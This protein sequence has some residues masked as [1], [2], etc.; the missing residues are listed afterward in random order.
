MTFGAPSPW[1][2]HCICHMDLLMF[3]CLTAAESITTYPSVKAI[4]EAIHIGSSWSNR[5]DI[6]MP[7]LDSRITSLCQT[8][9]HNLCASYQYQHLHSLHRDSVHS[10]VSSCGSSEFARRMTCLLRTG[11]N[12]RIQC[13]LRCCLGLQAGRRDL[14]KPASRHRYSYQCLQSVSSAHPS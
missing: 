10:D 12:P 3:R 6:R 11:Y 7:K 4:S 14:H 9:A 1:P 8:P 2:E 5:F 13:L